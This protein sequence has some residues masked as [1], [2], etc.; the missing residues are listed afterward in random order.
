MDVLNDKYQVNEE[1]SLLY[2]QSLEIQQKINNPIK[3]NSSKPLKYFLL[4]K[5]WVDKYKDQKNYNIIKQSIDIKSFVDYNIFKSNL[6]RQDKS[7]ITNNDNDSDNDNS[8]IPYID[9]NFFIRNNK[10]NIEYPS[11]FFP[12]REDILSNYNIDKKYLYELLIGEN[13][14]FIFDNKSNN[15]YN[16]FI[17]SINYDND[18]ENIDDFF[19]NVNNILKYFD[20]TI[21]KK[22]MDI[23]CDKGLNEYYKIRNFTFKENEEIPIIDRERIGSALTISNQ[24]QTPVKFDSEYISELG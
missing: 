24:D 20:K 11:H 13:K 22:E 21:L 23:I 16:I 14:I 9:N 17:C 1:M 18:E 10:L 19:L 12:I 5:N 4:S 8:N 3:Q 2:A 6:M 15:T 7:K